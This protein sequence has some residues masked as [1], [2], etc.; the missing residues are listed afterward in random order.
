MK[1]ALKVLVAS[2][3]LLSVSG[4][5]TA[6]AGS[7]CNTCATPA[8]SV[9][10]LDY[11]KLSHAQKVKVVGAVQQFMVD[12][13]R[14]HPDA[15][16]ANA[17][18]FELLYAAVEAL[19]GALISDAVAEGA[20]CFKAGR[21]G[22]RRGRTCVL[23]GNALKNYKS[24]EKVAGEKAKIRCDET[25][26][27][28]ACIDSL[29]WQSRSV[30]CQEAATKASYVPA[31]E[32]AFRKS[33][34]GLQAVCGKST[35]GACGALTAQLTAVNAGLANRGKDN[36]FFSFSKDC[37]YV[38]GA[39]AKVTSVYREDCDG[40]VIKRPVC[41]GRMQ[42]HAIKCVKTYNAPNFVT[43]DIPVD[44]GLSGIYSPTN[45]VAADKSV[46][47]RCFALEGGKCPD[48]NVCAMDMRLMDEAAHEKYYKSTEELTAITADT[49]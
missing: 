16:A 5:G 7:S 40:K 36:P 47:V 26:F 21:L 10:E 3:L 46:E 18:R 41:T 31:D 35:A 29:P 34:E 44:G 42:A 33:M 32:A 1:F 45:G 24:C 49:K 8:R 30:R 37:S 25:V 13:D 6:L 2:S 20:V 14:E 12:Y 39:E 15:S 9:W 27:G 28:G 4:F 11:G 22:K 17:Q 48:A 19:H 38:A 23:S 43:S